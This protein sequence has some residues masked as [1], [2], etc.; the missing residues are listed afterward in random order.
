MA[1]SLLVVRHSG[2]FTLLWLYRSVR[3]TVVLW[4]N[5]CS[6]RSVLVCRSVVSGA[7]ELVRRQPGWAGLLAGDCGQHAF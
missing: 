2:T 5:G 6:A 4:S 3:G 7:C 1:L